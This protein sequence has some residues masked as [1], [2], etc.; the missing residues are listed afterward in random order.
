[1]LKGNG[2]KNTMKKI[3][4]GSQTAWNCFLKLTINNIAPIIGMAVGAKSK[5]AQVGQA[6]TNIIK[7]I[8]SGRNLSFTDMHGSGLRL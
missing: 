6:T 5:V 1:M 3:L 2:F 4:K 8:S 7:S